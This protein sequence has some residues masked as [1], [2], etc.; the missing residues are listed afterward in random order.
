[1]TRTGQS[2]DG[3]GR[4]ARG[5]RTCLLKMLLGAPSCHSPESSKRPGT[6]GGNERCL[7]P[8]RPPRPPTVPLNH[9][10]SATSLEGPDGCRASVSAG[11]LP[12]R[13][14]RPQTSTRGRRLCMGSCVCGA[15]DR[16]GRP[17]RH[18]DGVLGGRLSSQGRLRPVGPGR[19]PSRV[20]HSPAAFVPALFAWH[21]L[22]EALRRKRPCSPVRAPSP[23]PTPSA[24]GGAAGGTRLGQPAQDQPSEGA[25]PGSPPPR[26]LRTGLG[27]SSF[28]SRC[29]RL[30]TREMGAMRQALNSQSC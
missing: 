23:C 15:E 30:L 19:P 2:R 5:P 16:T 21:L 24:R 6:L 26:L 10:F 8:W 11:S 27:T 14:A 3:P 20:S 29:L 17:S 9:P 4:E 12:G 7:G 18:G 22:G 25:W 1:M 13:A 28:I